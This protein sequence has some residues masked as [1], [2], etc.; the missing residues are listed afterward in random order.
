MSMMALTYERHSVVRFGPCIDTVEFRMLSSSPPKQFDAFSYIRAFDVEQLVTLST[1]HVARLG[2]ALN[3]KK[4][5]GFAV[6]WRAGSQHSTLDRQQN[7]PMGHRV[8]VP[9]CHPP[10]ISGSPRCARTTTATD[11]PKSQRGVA[12]ALDVGARSRNLEGRTRP[13]ANICQCCDMYFGKYPSVA[14]AWQ[15]K[16]GRVALGCHG[17]VA[18]EAIQGDLG[19]SSFEAREASSRVACEGRFR[20]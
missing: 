8:S 16:V 10:L 15:R 5:R 7:H 11:M 20:E 2:L 9:R 13:S 3:A 17:R 14:G 1:T 4:I 12:P 18:V 6:F 19:W